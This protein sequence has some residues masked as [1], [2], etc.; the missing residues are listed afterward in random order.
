M[1][2][3]V[4]ELVRWCFS[5]VRIKSD[6]NDNSKPDKAQKA[7]KIDC[8]ISMLEALGTYLAK[9]GGFDISSL[10]SDVLEQQKQS[11]DK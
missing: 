7:Q 1:I 8:V 2:I 11:A 4:S 3:D 5:N 6:H 10:L 9:S